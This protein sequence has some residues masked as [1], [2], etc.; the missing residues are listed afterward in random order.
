MEHLFEYKGELDELRFSEEEKAAMIRRLAAEP[1]AKKKPRLWR[2]V[3]IAA[4]VTAVLVVG[5]G[6]SG[7]LKSA[8]EVFAPLFGQEVAQTAVIDKI[9]RPIGASDT[10]N[11]VTITADAIMGD[12]YNAVIVYTIS[13]DDGTALLPE[14]VEANALLMGGF[15]GAS[16]DVMGGSHGSSHFVDET[17]GDNAIQ[18]V[19]SISADYPLSGCTATAEFQDLCRWDETAEKPVTLV[20]G[21]WKFCFDAVYEDASVTLG[22]GE[23]FTQDGLT[24][25]VDQIT[26]SPVAVKVDY[27]VDSEVKWSDAPSGREDPS[28]SLQMQRY[29]GNVAI[30]LTKTDGTEVTLSGCGGSLK[31]ERGVTVCDKG[32]V[33][34]MILPLEEIESVSVG[35]IVYEVTGS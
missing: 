3:L 25:T 16:L 30:A 14:G 15:G 21:H 32:G 17:P 20:E 7:V 10:D 4:V 27:T 19:Q 26:L 2:T 13:R 29:L 9:G 28:D 35:G 5:A 24:F 22:G 31:P 18:L 1:A 34:D 33:F 8:V 23:T 12:R 6:A 11:G